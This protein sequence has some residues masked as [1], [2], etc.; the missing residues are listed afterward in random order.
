MPQHPGDHFKELV[1]TALTKSSISDL[2]E[3][4]MALYRLSCLVADIQLRHKRSK[5]NGNTGQL[6]GQ[7]S[8]VDFSLEVD[9]RE[10][11]DELEN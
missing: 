7:Y 1:D 11:S 5:Q 9:Q 6:P 4:A 3:E 8:P 10:D 2:S